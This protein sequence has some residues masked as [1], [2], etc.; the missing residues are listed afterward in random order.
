M[1]DSSARARA[2][3]ARNSWHDGT[4][5]SMSMAYLQSG[6]GAQA[7]K[8]ATMIS[9]VCYAPHGLVVHFAGR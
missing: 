6:P 4:S 7:M 1:P 2:C 9:V 3:A 5:R 8:I